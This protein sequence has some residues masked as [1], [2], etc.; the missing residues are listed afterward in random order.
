[1]CGHG[2]VVLS[3]GYNSFMLKGENLEAEQLRKPVLLLLIIITYTAPE[4][5][6]HCLYH[7]HLCHGNC[8]QLSCYGVHKCT[9]RVHPA[10]GTFILSLSKQVLLSLSCTA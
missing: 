5:V 7:V 4:E 2:N 8:K 9:W 1:M 3:F 10:T 6:H